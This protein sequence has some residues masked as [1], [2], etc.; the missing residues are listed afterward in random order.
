MKFHPLKC[1]VL[2]V[3]LAKL[4]NNLSLSLPFCAFNYSMNDVLL[5]FVSSEKDLGILIN[6]KLSWHEQHLALY[7]K[8]S[9]RLGLVKRS[10]HFV[11][12]LRQKRAIYLSLVRSLYEHLSP[13]WRPCSISATDKLEKIQRRAVKWILSEQLFHYSDI[14]YSK[15]LRDLDLLPLSARFTQSDL[16]LFHK[17]YYNICPLSFPSYISYSNA[18][19]TTYYSLRTSTYPPDYLG[20]SLPSQQARLNYG[21]D[22]MSV[23]ITIDIRLQL[24][25]RSFYVRTALAWN[26]LPLNI[27]SIKS[28]TGFKIAVATHLWSNEYDPIIYDELQED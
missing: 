19:S 23:D 13:V 15:R 26:R 7:S 27:R 24:F 28:T 6:T 12:C 21:P 10:C 17:V 5:D 1:K 18:E 2:R 4:E 22:T 9:S 25:A 16:C 14:E 8:S 20:S 11:V 3:S